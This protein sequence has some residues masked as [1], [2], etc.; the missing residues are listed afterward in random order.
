MMQHWTKLQA[1][2]CA[3]KVG[4]VLVGADFALVRSVG[5]WVDSGLHVAQI[6]SIV[7]TIHLHCEQPSLTGPLIQPH[8]TAH[9]LALA[10]HDLVNPLTLVCSSFILGSASCQLYIYFSFFFCGILFFL[11]FLSLTLSLD[12]TL[13]IPGCESVSTLMI[14]WIFHLAKYVILSYPECTSILALGNLTT[15]RP[16][17]FLRL[18]AKKNRSSILGPSNDSGVVLS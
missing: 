11:I 13:S 17:L 14:I 4:R 1:I 12:L 18:R 16:T 8:T 2:S 10:S 3:F 7:R 5:L 9:L 6:L 15:M